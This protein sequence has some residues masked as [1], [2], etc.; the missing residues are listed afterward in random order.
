MQN[1]RT[2]KIITEVIQYF[3]RN[4]GYAYL[5][6]LKKEGVHT[7][8]VR[9]LL[10]DGIIEKVKPGVYKL[11]D[12]PMLSNQS[13]ID[14]CMAMPKAVVCLHS[15]LSYYGLT[16][17]LP[18]LVLVAI[19]RDSKPVK[20]AYPP[21]EVFYFSRQNYRTEIDEIHE[22]TGKFKIYNIEKTIIDCFRYRNKLGEDTALEGLRNYLKGENSNINKLL[23]YAKIGRM[24][25]IIKPYIEAML[26]Q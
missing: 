12:L 10:K 25:N 11:T 4:Y 6:D 8:T 23:K 20:I 5:K 7:D 18:S 13:M 15:A 22:K 14:I 9:K 3:K 21:V 24:T 1:N 26:T 2:E 19:S 17:T 16:T